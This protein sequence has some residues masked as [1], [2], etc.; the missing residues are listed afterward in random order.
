V[1]VQDE[2]EL[3]YF[4]RVPA[5]P[6]AYRVSEQRMSIG[7]L[8]IGADEVIALL[9]AVVT[10]FDA[11]SAGSDRALATPIPVPRDQGGRGLAPGVRAPDFD[12]DATAS[13]R[14]SIA[15]TRGRWTLLVFWSP[16]CRHCDDVAEALA[17]ATE[18]QAELNLVIVC[19]GAQADR[20]RLQSLVGARIPIVVQERRAISRR[21]RTYEA[22][23]AYLIDPD[24]RI[25]APAAIGVQ[26]VLRLAEESLA[27][28][29]TT[30]G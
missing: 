10:P 21:Y 9:P 14:A 22:P 2:Q 20:A 7:S 23:A 29:G 13:G 24:R 4:M 1:V 26:A 28:A 8:A 3:L 5:T 18:L 17:A 30:P 16:G 27:R 6:A 25:A 11:D 19:R 12:L 15:D